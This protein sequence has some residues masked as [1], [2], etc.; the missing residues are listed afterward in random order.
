MVKRPDNLVEAAINYGQLQYFVYSNLFT[1]L[2]NLCFWTYYG[3]APFSVFIMIVY[4]LFHAAVL[5]SCRKCRF[6]ASF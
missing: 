3:T 6:K 1:G 5:N 4:F 2:C